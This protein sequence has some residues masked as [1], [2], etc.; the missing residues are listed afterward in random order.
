MGGCKGGGVEG[1]VMLHSL[2]WQA[3]WEH[4]AFFILRACVCALVC[5]GAW[6]FASVCD[7]FV[8]LGGGERERGFIYSHSKSSGQDPVALLCG[9]N[10]QQVRKRKLGLCKSLLEYGEQFFFKLER[11]S[12]A[13]HQLLGFKLVMARLDTH[14]KVESWLKVHFFG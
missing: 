1:Y 13:K 6:P 12:S 4:F 2:P 3:R 14:V 9:N 10:Y 5:A 7:R 11:H 8:P